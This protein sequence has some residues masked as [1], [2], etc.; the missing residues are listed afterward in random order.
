MLGAFNR[1]KETVDQRMVHSVILY[2]VPVWEIALKYKKYQKLLERVQKNAALRATAACR[3]AP[4]EAL[5]VLAGVPP[6]Q[7]LVEEKTC[8]YRAM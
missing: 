6:I 1:K 8:G 7:V 4:T 5:S 3:T 2:G